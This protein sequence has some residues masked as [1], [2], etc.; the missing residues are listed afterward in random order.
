MLFEIQFSE[1]A[2][3]QLRRL[4]SRDRKT[5]LDAVEKQLTHQPTRQTRNRKPM[6]SNTLATWELRIG[7]LR[8]YYDVETQPGSVVRVQAIG[9]KLRDRVYI[10]GKEV[11]L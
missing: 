9:I 10:N 1:D 11:D 7:K 8:V 3:Q 6:R 5:I 2:T 4:P